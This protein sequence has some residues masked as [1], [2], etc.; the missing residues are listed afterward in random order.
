LN[1]ILV[2]EMKEVKDWD[3]ILSSNEPY[4]SCAI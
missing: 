1:K 4:H 3:C 2:K